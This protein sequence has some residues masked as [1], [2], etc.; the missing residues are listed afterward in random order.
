MNELIGVLIPQSNW[1]EVCAMA[2]SAKCRPPA[3][4]NLDALLKQTETLS[5]LEK[6]FLLS[7]D[8][9]SLRMYISYRFPHLALQLGLS[10]RI[11]MAVYGTLR[12]GDYSNHP[13]NTKHLI[14]HLDISAEIPGQIFNIKDE[15]PG[16]IESAGHVK[17]EIVQLADYQSLWATDL[18]EEYYPHDPYSSE[19]LRRGM[20]V[21]GIDFWVYYY[22][23]PVSAQQKI[24]GG[25][26]IAW[27]KERVAD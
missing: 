1:E 17:A 22:N 23:F 19:Y 26:W 6:D 11:L 15:Y 21:M 2:V 27:Q 7:S 10:Q 20:S 9:P 24:P 18:Y 16:L 13:H 5:Q 3:I 14:T 8:M 25:D 12:Q 4:K